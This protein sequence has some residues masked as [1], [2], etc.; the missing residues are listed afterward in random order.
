MITY[1]DRNSTVDNTSLSCRFCFFL[2][3]QTNKNTHSQPH[4]FWPQEARTGLPFLRSIQTEIGKQI[5]RGKCNS[6]LQIISQLK[7]KERQW[8]SWITESDVR[9][10]MALHRASQL[11]PAP[12]EQAR[13]KVAAHSASECCCR[14]A[15]R[16]TWLVSESLVLLQCIAL[17]KKK[18]RRDCLLLLSQTERNAG[19]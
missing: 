14:I 10:Q 7:E 2:N 8:H 6:G 18:G 15:N 5:Q 19:L 9:H 12:W 11:K 3:K 13:R 17:F 1:N 16:L 4:G